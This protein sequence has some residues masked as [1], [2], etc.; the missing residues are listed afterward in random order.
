MRGR[1]LALLVLSGVVS[2]NAQTPK[3]TF[4]VASIRPNVSGPALPTL[5]MRPG[6]LFIATAQPLIRL[7]GFGYSVDDF[8]L[9]GGPGWI[10][11]ARF[12]VNARAAGEVPY[13]QMR[14]MMQSLLEDRF[15]LVTHKEQREMPI[16]AVVLAR[17]DG[18]LGSGVQRIDDCK[19]AKFSGPP[20]GRYSGCGSIS[21]VASIASM[22]LGAPVIDKTGLTGTFAVAVNFSPEGVRPFPGDAPRDA[23]PTERDLPSFRDALREQLGFK[24]ESTRGP[25]DVLVIDSVQQPTEN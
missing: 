21:V 19:N 1:S 17:E 2:V 4:E 15:K 7:M 8:R 11:D 10:R 20:A 24:L 9:I 3:P 18:R 12:D 23:L 16:Y 14:L 6:G 25:V 22:M 13:D 5:S